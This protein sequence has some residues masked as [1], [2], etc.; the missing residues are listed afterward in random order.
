MTAAHTLPP[1]KLLPVAFLVQHVWIERVRLLARADE[2]VVAALTYGSF[3]KGEG[4][5]FSDIEF[6]LFVRD[7]ALA[8]VDRVRWVEA[9][10]APL[11]VLT[12]L[13]NH[14]TV[15]IFE[16]YR[17]GEFHFAPASELNTVR[18]WAPN[19]P[20]PPPESMLLVDRTGELR[21]HLQYLHGH[22]PRHGGPP[23]MLEVIG[24]FINWSVQ[25]A[26]VLRRGEDARALNTLGIL[27]V[28]LLQLARLVEGTTLHWPTPSKGAETD[29]SDE[30]YAR[31]RACTAA[32]DPHA[33]ERAYAHT[34][35]W[36]QELAGILLG[37]VGKEWPAVFAVPFGALVSPVQASGTLEPPG[38][39][40]R[41]P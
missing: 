11:A 1:G 10:A 24:G 39:V 30:A 13:P 37:R 12:D 23:E 17:R 21:R 6:W 14:L 27:H 34:W 35:A 16:G 31:L 5:E 36:G 33:L 22:P 25:G 28:H 26:H 38:S 20:F 15:A 29:L 4:D 8:Q 18:S 40:A 2:R 32:L 41:R 9:V 3:T 19:G 7:D